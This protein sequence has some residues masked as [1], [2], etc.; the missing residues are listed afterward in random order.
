MR[1]LQCIVY[2]YLNKIAIS[3]R[4]VSF[5]IPVHK[6]TR[7][8]RQ[9]QL[10][11]LHSRTSYKHS[12]PEPATSTPLQNQLQSLHSRTSYKHSTRTF[13]TGEYNFYFA[14]SC[15]S[16]CHLIYMYRFQKSMSLKRPLKFSFHLQH[17]TY[18]FQYGEY[19]VSYTYRGTQTRCFV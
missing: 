2:I 13:I 6:T 17:R 4:I 15:V 10:Q 14:N 18:I 11:A 9:D 7:Y 1:T 3:P 5:K 19:T 12:T 8:F 16:L